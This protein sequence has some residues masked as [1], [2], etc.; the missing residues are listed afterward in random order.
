[1]EAVPW[2]AQ[3]LPDLTEGRIDLALYVETE[4]PL[5]GDFHIRDLFDDSF[6]CLVRADHPALKRLGANGRVDR[7]ALG[8]FPR[9]LMTYPD[10]RRMLTQDFLAKTLGGPASAAFATPYFLASPRLV[11]QSDVVL[12]T[13]PRLARMLVRPGASVMIELPE[14]PTY[15]YRLAW[16]ASSNGDEM[17]S[18]VRANILRYGRDAEFKGTL[19]Y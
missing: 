4:V 10:G 11:E 8:R 12:C 6:A 1:M 15:T 14:A 19:G 3:T 5:N 13:T 9:V 17:R 18:W 2:N 16:H 7:K